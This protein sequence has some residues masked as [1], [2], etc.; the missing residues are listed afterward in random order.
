M[1]GASWPSK[2]NC[3]LIIRK[4]STYSKCMDVTYIHTHLIFPF[5]GSS[6]FCKTSQSME[7]IFTHMQIDHSRGQPAFICTFFYPHPIVLQLFIS[8]PDY[9]RGSLLT[10][11]WGQILHTLVFY[12]QRLILDLLSLTQEIS[13]LH[14]CL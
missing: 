5:S 10:A 6:N 14:L 8:A 13:F 2:I 12:S 1:Q 7:Y 3:S 11:R 4:Q 9:L